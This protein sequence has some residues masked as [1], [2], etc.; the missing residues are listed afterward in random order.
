M[1]TLLLIRHAKSSWESADLADFDRPL[2]ARGREDAPDMARRLLKRRIKPDLLVS[3]PAKRARKT[4]E[5]FAGVIKFPPERILLLPELYEAGSRGFYEVIAGLE[6]KVR[7]LA[8]FSHNPGITLFANALTGV[9]VD[10]MPTCAIFAL[11]V[12]TEDWKE[13]EK[14]GKEF[15]FFDYPK[16]APSGT[17]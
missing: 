12:M 11:Q 9:Q 15:L 6:E 3:S 7:T 14:A 1:K 5:L 16:A 10:N 17:P 2:N 8:L 4:A 13:F